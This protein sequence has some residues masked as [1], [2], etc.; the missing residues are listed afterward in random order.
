LFTINKI[1]KA[2]EREAANKFGVKVKG[3][4]Q[5]NLRAKYFWEGGPGFNQSNPMT[6][7]G[8]KYKGIA[9]CVRLLFF[10]PFGL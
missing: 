1:R 7:H 2:C 10:W 4:P 5:I 8:A 9:S 3:N 6:R